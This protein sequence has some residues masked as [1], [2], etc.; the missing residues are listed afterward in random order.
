[1]THTVSDPDLMQTLDVI[2]T[3]LGEFVGRRQAEQ[4][5]DRIKED[6]LAL[7]HHE[8]RT[9]LTAIVGY[10]EM[11]AKMEGENL[12]ARGLKFIDVI[13]R[14]SKRE[15][16]LV[17]DL[18]MITRIES[19]TFHLE[20]GTVDLVEIAEQE[21]EAARPAAAHEG[22]ELS[23]ESEPVPPM[24]GDAERIG[25]VMDNL[26][27]NAIK[28]TPGG[29]GVQMRL[30]CADGSAVIEVEDS[31]S[32]ISPE[33]RPRVFDRLYRASSATE[34]HVPGTGLGLTIVKAI[35]E[36]HGG[37]VTVGGAE[38]EGAVFRVELPIRTPS[39]NG[40][41]AE[42]TVIP[43]SNGTEAVRS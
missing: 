41:S 28:F 30:T 26:L 7:V 13:R 10:T 18:L 43:A 16:R 11:L 24:E 35:V 1:M 25:Q 32:G 3:Q 34:D 39:S 12:S 17:G 27:S 40:A 37:T 2:G 42:G 5:S 36:A 9:P 14:N 31:G 23:F 22:L 21:I 6:F 29:K 4:E 38:G 19:G 33:D 15:M 8:L 20:P